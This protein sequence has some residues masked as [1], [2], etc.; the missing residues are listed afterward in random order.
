MLKLTSSRL[1]LLD[2][3]LPFACI[4][5]VLFSA[6]YTHHNYRQLLSDCSEKQL[7]QDLVC[8]QIM[9][10]VLATVAVS[11]MKRAT[12]ATDRTYRQTVIDHPMLPPAAA[13]RRQMLP[14]V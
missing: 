6:L 14:L 12:A 10:I 3:H 11:A 2:W 13:R 7:L 4:T 8:M 1:G 5:V 9:G